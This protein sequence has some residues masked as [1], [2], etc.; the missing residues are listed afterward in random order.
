MQFWDLRG[1]LCVRGGIKLSGS[2]L[3]VIELLGSFVGVITAVGA[4]EMKFADD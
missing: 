1:W 2:F 3:G 4:I